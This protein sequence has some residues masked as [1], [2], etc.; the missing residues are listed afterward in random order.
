MSLWQGAWWGQQYFGTQWWGEDAGAPPVTPPGGGQPTATG[1]WGGGTGG[2]RRR[3]SDYDFLDSTS[4][5]RQRALERER[6]E[7]TAR[8]QR[9]IDR[10][11]VKIAALAP[12]IAEGG[13]LDGG[14]IQQAAPFNA[15]LASLQPTEGMIEALVQAVLD[16]IAWMEAEAAEEEAVVRMMME[17]L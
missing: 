7:I 12:T 17:Q 15:L 16:R 8:Q 10:A 5:K 14:A 4:V 11:A 9:A 13:L 2:K 1:G 6:L 3:A